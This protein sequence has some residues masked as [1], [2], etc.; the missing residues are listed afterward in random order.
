MVRLSFPSLARPLVFGLALWT[1]ALVA[2]EAQVISGRFVSEFHIYAEAT[3]AWW[4]GAEIYEDGINGF[5]YLPSSAVL[6]TPWAYLPPCWAMP[7]G[8]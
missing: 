4:Q 2:I 8:A 7:C 3:W 6:F 1:A 5:L